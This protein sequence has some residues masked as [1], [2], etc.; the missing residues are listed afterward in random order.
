MHLPNA[1]FVFEDAEDGVEGR[2]LG[3]ECGCKNR[4]YIE[5]MLL[6]I[7]G[8]WFFFFFHFFLPPTVIPC[9]ITHHANVILTFSDVTLSL[10][11]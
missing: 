2:C 6:N 9:F 1:T 7:Q 10:N 8:C 5:D 11:K 4:F 3:F